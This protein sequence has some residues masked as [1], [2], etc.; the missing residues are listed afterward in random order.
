MVAIRAAAMGAAAL[1]AALGMAVGAD[2]V[3]ADP[4]GAEVPGADG[5]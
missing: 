5:A 3:L 1:G 4:G 2:G